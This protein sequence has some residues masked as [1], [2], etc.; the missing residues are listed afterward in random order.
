LQIDEDVFL[1]LHHPFRVI[2]HSCDPSCCVRNQNDLYAL[3]DIN[4]KDEITFDYS[5]TVSP[6]IDWNMPC[7]CGAKNCRRQVGNVLTIPTATLQKY[8]ELNAFPDFIK[9][10]LKINSIP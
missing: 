6:Y 8:M 2:N 1:I 4:I 3:R 5:S 9:M 10:Q 7:F